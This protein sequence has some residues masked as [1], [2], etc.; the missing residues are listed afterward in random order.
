MGGWE[1][2]ATRAG[3]IVRVEVN[4]AEIAIV[5]TYDGAAVARAAIPYPRHGYGGHELLLSPDERYLAL[6]LYSGQSEIGYELFAFPRLEHLHSFGYVLGEGNGPAFSPDDRFL[7]LAWS[8]NPGLVL[9]DLPDMPAHPGVSPHPITIEWAQL[10]LHD[11]VD[12]TATTCTI[13]VDLP[14]GFPVETDDSYWPEHL[15]LTADEIRFH[16][17]NDLVRIPLPL[18]PTIT[19]CGPRTT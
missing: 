19:I 17:W 10:R 13:S 14:A 2:L 5:V 3:E 6:W 8:T 4:D 9:V 15:A 12:D 1:Q 16:A 11:L 7:A 18:P